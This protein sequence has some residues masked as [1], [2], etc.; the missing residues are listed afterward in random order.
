MVYPGAIYLHEAKT[1]LVD[2]LDLEKNL[3]YL[4]MVDMDFYTEPKTETEVLLLNIQRHE[5]IPGA[6]KTYGE[7]SVTT[8]VTGYRRIQWYTHEI[9]GQE[10]LNLP[11]NILQTMG[12]WLALTEDAIVKLRNEGHWSADRNEYG[13]D[14]EHQRNQAR[15]RDGY[16]CQVCGLPEKGR[17]H[18]VHHK[19]PFR[20]FESMEAANHLSNLITLCANCHRRVETAVRIRSGL[21]GLAFA[22]G[23]LAPLF[24]MCDSNDLGVYSEPQSPLAEGAPVVV[25]YDQVSAGIGFSQKLYEIHRELIQ[26]TQ[27]LIVTCECLDGCPSCVGPG[28]ENGHGGKLETLAILEALCPRS[29]ND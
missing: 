4:H 17:A 15:A 12:F 1:F 11:P 7:I 13:A 29:P 26:R 8:R 27:E 18:H 16:R 22:F 3:A 5:S 14:W 28:G 25:L 2:S 6:F 9:L 10:E 24:L 21:S 19:T 23:H 20:T